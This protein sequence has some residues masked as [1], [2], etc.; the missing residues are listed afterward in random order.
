MRTAA[1][2]DVHEIEGWWQLVPATL[3]RFSYRWPHTDGILML[4]RN[5]LSAKPLAPTQNGRS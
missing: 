4:R 3:S 2:G 1:G 5:Y